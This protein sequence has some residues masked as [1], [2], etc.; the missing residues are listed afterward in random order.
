MNIEE[1]VTSKQI[2]I[3][4]KG[5]LIPQKSLFYWCSSV[6]TDG[7]STYHVPVDGPEYIENIKK[8]DYRKDFAAFTVAELGKFFPPDIML[9]F[10]RKDAW[11]WNS[12][13]GRHPV[14]TEANARA[15]FLIYH[16]K[17]GNIKL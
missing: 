4:L 5:L 14:N 15:K 7:K 9:P 2:S 12:S 6:K 8:Y 3:L 16:I 13:T 17:E 10:K 1:Q 11:Y